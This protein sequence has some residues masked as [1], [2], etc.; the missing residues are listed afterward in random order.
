MSG[1]AAGN[2]GA[3]FE[4]AIAANASDDPAL[5]PPGSGWSYLVTGDN[6][7]GE[8]SMGSDSALQPRSNGSACP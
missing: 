7:A 8:G 4:A 3:C 5:P 6:A 1:L 2:Y